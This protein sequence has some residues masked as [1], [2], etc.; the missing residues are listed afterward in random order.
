MLKQAATGGDRQTI[1]V[2]LKDAVA[3]KRLHWVD[4]YRTFN[5]AVDKCESVLVNELINDCPWTQEEQGKNIPV[6]LFQSGCG[7]RLD[8][9]Q[10]LLGWGRPQYVMNALSGTIKS[11]HLSIVEK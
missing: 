4:Y 5:F 7:G 1:L 8:V 6:L 9:I 2:L 11:G 3:Q 10:T